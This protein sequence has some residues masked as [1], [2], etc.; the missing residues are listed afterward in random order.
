MIRDASGATQQVALEGELQNKLSVSIIS[1]E[2]MSS[3]WEGVSVFVGGPTS[4]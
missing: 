1:I 3:S 2:M 4:R